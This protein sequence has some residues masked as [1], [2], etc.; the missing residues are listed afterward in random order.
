MHG[1]DWNRAEVASLGSALREAEAVQTAAREALGAALLVAYR[2]G[3][4]IRRLGVY[5]GIPSKNKVR[6]LING[7]ISDE[8]E[9][10]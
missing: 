6:R 2:Q 3:A 10:S 1:G 4:G 7:A 8:Q 5:A 9:G